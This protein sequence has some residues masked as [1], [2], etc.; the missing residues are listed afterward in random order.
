VQKENI[1]WNSSYA[2]IAFLLP[3]LTKGQFVLGASGG[4]LA[5][6]A[7]LPGAVVA[8]WCSGRAWSKV[9]QRA[10][11]Q[12]FILIMQIATLLTLSMWGKAPRIGIDYVAFSIPAVLG[13][14]V[15]LQI[16]AQ[17]S[18][19]RFRQL[20]N[21]FVAISGAAILIKTIA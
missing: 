13:A 8:V 10:V 21:A 3:K 7:A 16:F 17:L 15:G 6:L 14:M 1:P 9:E 4:L 2:A 18:D 5:P 19:V 12:P 11:Y 20:V